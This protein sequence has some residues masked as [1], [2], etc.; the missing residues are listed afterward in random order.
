MGKCRNSTTTSADHTFQK[1][2]CVN[3]GVSE[4]FCDHEGVT[5]YGNDSSTFHCI[6]CGFEI[7]TPYQVQCASCEKAETFQARPQTSHDVCVKAFYCTLPGSTA[8]IDPYVW[9]QCD[10]HVRKEE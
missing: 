5:A 2:V 1:G 10:F 6:K 7:V 3:C 8:I 4:P 9:R